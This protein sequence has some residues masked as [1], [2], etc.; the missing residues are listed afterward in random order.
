MQYSF[1]QGRKQDSKLFPLLILQIL[2]TVTLK[3]VFSKIYRSL[4]FTNMF[5]LGKSLSLNFI[6]IV[7]NFSF[8]FVAYGT[9]VYHW[10]K[11]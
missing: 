6:W 4:P 5:K 1:I 8:I 2:C 10:C 9:Y 3:M 11:L 7:T